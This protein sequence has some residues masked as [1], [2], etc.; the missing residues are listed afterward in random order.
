MK[1]NKQVNPCHIG[2]NVVLHPP[3]PKKKLFFHEVQNFKKCESRNTKMLI[4]LRESA[5]NSLISSYLVQVSTTYLL[6][7]HRRPSEQQICY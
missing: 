3:P 5:I 7:L 4:L 1:E 2:F 6:K